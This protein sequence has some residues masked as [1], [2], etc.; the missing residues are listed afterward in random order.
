MKSTNWDIY[1]SSAGSTGTLDENR[2][3]IYKLATI[4]G[5][6]SLLHSTKPDLPDT[7]PGTRAT[8]PAVYPT[9]TAA[10]SSTTNATTTPCEPGL[11]CTN[12]SFSGAPTSSSAR[13][14]T[15]PRSTASF[16]RRQSTSGAQS[17]LAF[18]QTYNSTTSQVRF[19]PIYP[20]MLFIQFA[21]R[22][23][24]ILMWTLGPFLTITPHQMRRRNMIF[25]R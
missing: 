19:L 17:C 13:A 4:P 10:C 5:A 9:T 11:P 22:S 14:T 1:D 7:A 23:G 15:I 20:I 6:T 12:S 2:H 21:I 8:T 18:Y 24:V 3:V 25:S 16:F